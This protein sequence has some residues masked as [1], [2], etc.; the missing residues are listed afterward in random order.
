MLTIS[1]TSSL[2]LLLDKKRSAFTI[3]FSTFPFSILLKSKIKVEDTSCS[4]VA[5]ADDDG[6]DD[7]ES[8]PAIFLCCLRN[9]VT[10]QCVSSAA[11]KMKRIDDDGDEKMKS[12]NACAFNRI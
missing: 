5:M 11:L 12:A 6:D 9:S 10:A 1:F 4:I 2:S 3:K 8:A 7:D